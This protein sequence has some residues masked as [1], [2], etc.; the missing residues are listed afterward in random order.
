[1]K[2]LIV[3]DIALMQKYSKKILSPYAQCD[4]ASNGEEALKAYVQASLD[5]EPYDVI[6]LD[7]MLPGINGLQILERIRGSEH[8]ENRVKIIIVT[9]LNNCNFVSKAIEGGCD[10]YIVKPFNNDDIERHLKTLN[11]I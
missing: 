11:L 3:E 9:A 7:I 6:F 10:G 8:S 2:F 4:I 5:N 1:M